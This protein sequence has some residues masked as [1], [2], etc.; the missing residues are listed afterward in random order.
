MRAGPAYRLGWWW[1]VATVACRGRPRSAGRGRATPRAAV[2]VGEAEADTPVG[3]VAELSRA[4]VA[5]EDVEGAQ[6]ESCVVACEPPTMPGR[7]FRPS[8]SCCGAPMP[9]RALLAVI[10]PA[11]QRECAPFPRQVAHGSETP[12]GTPHPAPGKGQPKHVVAHEA[13]ATH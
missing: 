8:T 3:L 5:E 2:R 6:R 4:E 12:Q 10:H 1:W 7:S 9:A 11:L 13:D